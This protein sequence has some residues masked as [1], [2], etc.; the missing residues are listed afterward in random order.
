[1]S[2]ELLILVLN[3]SNSMGHSTSWPYL[4]LYVYLGA[5]K[6]MNLTDLNSSLTVHMPLLRL[7]GGGGG[8]TKVRSRRRRRY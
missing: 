1:M 7:G 3:N 2:L 6:I 4:C 8:G 5:Y